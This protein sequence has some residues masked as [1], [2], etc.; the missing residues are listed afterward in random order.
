MIK[1][2]HLSTMTYFL[3]A[4]LFISYIFLFKT[5]TIFY[6]FNVV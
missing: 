6:E 3:I 2:G 4:K 1:I 5:Q